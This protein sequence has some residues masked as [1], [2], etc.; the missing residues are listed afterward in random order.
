MVLGVPGRMDNYPESAIEM[1]IFPEGER[2]RQIMKKVDA[3]QD[4]DEIMLLTSEKLP[5]RVRYT[6]VK[7]ENGKPVCAYATAIP[8][9]S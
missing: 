1:C 5:F 7:D 3:G 8:I 9:G 4:I 6:V 2:Y